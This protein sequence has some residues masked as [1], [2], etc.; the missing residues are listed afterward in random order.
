MACE[1]CQT[2]EE[3]RRCIINQAAER[4]DQITP[5]LTQLNSLLALAKEKGLINHAL[6][7]PIAASIDKLATG[8]QRSSKLFYEALESDEQSEPE[9]E[10]GPA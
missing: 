7:V 9:P 8:V 2:E 5:N 1:N 6:S 4:Y 3:C 10:G